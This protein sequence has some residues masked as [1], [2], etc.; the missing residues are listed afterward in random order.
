MMPGHAR[1]IPAAVTGRR[2]AARWPFRAENTGIMTSSSHRPGDNERCHSHRYGD[3][4][5]AD[6]EVNT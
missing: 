6:A 4:V 1:R 5:R 3:N 2:Q